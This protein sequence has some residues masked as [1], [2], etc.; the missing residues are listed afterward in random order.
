[1]KE[2]IDQVK[3]GFHVLPDFLVFGAFLGIIMSLFSDT[4]LGLG[5][6]FVFMGIWAAIFI[7]FPLIILFLD[8]INRIFRLEPNKK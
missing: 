1:M 8:I 3:E 2:L 7:G 4:A 5:C 6:F